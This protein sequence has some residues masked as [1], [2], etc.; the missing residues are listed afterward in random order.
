LSP[1]YNVD[2][3]FTN[4]TRVANGGLDGFYY[5]YSANLLGSSVTWHGLVFALGPANGPDA[6]S[7]A[8]VAL[9]AGHFSTL[10]ILAGATDLPRTASG[11]IVVTY[12]DGTKSTFTQT[13]S[14]W[15]YPKNYAGEAIATATAYR[16]TP[17]GTTQ[18]GPWYVYGYAYALNNAK[19]VASVT[20]P[21]SPQI[22]TLSAV[23]QP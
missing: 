20:L 6:V 10:N 2:A 22:W 17:S 16:V 4:G 8:T 9:P 14:D 12:T 19:T 21:A 3:V 7:N 15:G 13:F 23:L 11:T 1:Y 5:A 18:A